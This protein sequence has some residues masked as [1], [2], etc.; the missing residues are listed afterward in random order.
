M[1]ESW[2]SSNWSA[3]TAGGKLEVPTAAMQHPLHRADLFR[4]VAGW[5]AGQACDFAVS[6]TDGSRVHIQCFSRADGVAMF[7][8]H[9]DKWDPNRSPSHM[10]RH[11]LE[12]TP[13]GVG[14]LVFGLLGLAWL[15][16]SRGLELV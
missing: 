11:A 5:P 1:W 13:A 4:A 12:E 6:M 14:L 15:A 7:R 3:L 2:I 10:L 16:S 9:R 8:V